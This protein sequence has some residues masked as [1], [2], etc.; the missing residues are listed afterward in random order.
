MK[1]QGNLAQT[2]NKRNRSSENYPNEIEVY[3][4]S[5]KQFK[6]SIIKMLYRLKKMRHEQN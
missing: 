1:K 2:K 4:L 3:E 6:I 5:D